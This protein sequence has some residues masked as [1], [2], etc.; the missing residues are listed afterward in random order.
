VLEQRPAL[1][2]YADRPVVIG[3]RPEDLEDASLK[4]DH[5]E[6]ARFKADVELVEALGSELMVHARIDARRAVSGDP[7]V[8]EEPDTGEGATV[9]GRFSP[10]SRIGRGQTADIAVEVDMIYLF[11]AETGLAIRS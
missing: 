11:D 3:I 1:R 9:V 4:P 2:A 10:R 8:V 6:R 5:P 7:D